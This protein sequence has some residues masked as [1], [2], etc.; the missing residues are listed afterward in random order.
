MV[1]LS[2]S[3]LPAGPPRSAGLGEFGRQRSICKMKAATA[4]LENPWFSGESPVHLQDGKQMIGLFM[5]N[6]VHVGLKTIYLSY[7]HQPGRRTHLQSTVSASSP[8]THN[9]LVG[10]QGRRFQ[11]GSFWSP[12]QK[13]N[14][15]TPA[16]QGDTIQRRL[17]GVPNLWETHRRGTNA[18]FQGKT[19]RGGLKQT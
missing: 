4:F 14:E 8:P 2:P 3:Q 10:T 9:H 18:V 11:L 17:S 15:S 13:K 12:P 1:A 19:T 6:S 7:R 5:G 16:I